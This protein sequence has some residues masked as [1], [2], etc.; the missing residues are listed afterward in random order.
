MPKGKEEDS[1]DRVGEYLEEEDNSSS[2]YNVFLGHVDEF[3]VPGFHSEIESI[4]V[5]YYKLAVVVYVH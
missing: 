1:K 3:L 2:I 4:I 5:D